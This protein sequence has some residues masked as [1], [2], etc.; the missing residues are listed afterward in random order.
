MII[1]K[2]ISSWS[3]PDLLDIPFKI[4]IYFTLI[5]TLDKFQFGLLNIAM[6]IFSY[7]AISQ[8]GIVDWLM[9]ELPKKYALNVQSDSLIAESYSFV[10]FNQLIL[11]IITMLMVFIFGNSSLFFKLACGAYLLH[12][13]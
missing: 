12:T 10:F 6:M 5:G 1:F 2:N 13:I 11:V 3:L 8:I 9:Y 7:Q 4:I